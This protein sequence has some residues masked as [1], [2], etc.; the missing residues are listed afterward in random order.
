M[1]IAVPAGV[2]SAG[3][4]DPPPPLGR[5]DRV[6]PPLDRAD[7]LRPLSKGY[8]PACVAMTLSR[9]DNRYR[10][11]VVAF[12]G[13]SVRLRDTDRD[14]D[15]D[16]DIY[17]GDR[18]IRKIRDLRPGQT[19]TF[20]TPSGMSYSLSLTSIDHPTRTVRIALKPA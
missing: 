18:R 16:L 11:R 8:K 7:E 15:A 13:L 12:D 1:E 10:R 20:T 2:P 19:E 14:P 5:V 4:P 17:A 9:R 6:R 3:G